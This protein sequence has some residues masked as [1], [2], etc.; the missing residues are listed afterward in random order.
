MAFG[1]DG[2]GNWESEL[3][4]IQDRD[5]SIPISASKFN[6]LIQLNLKQSLPTCMTIDSQTK[7]IANVDISNFKV[8]N[9]ANPTLPKDAVNK[10][11]LDLVETKVDTNTTNIG[12]NTTNIGTNTSAIALNTAKGEETVLWTGSAA[13]GT[14]T[15]SDDINNYK[16][17]QLQAGLSVLTS[18]KFST[19]EYFKTVG[20]AKPIRFS[21][22]SAST[23]IIVEVYY[24]DDFTIG[25]INSA[26]G[27]VFES[28]RGIK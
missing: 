5:D 18:T 9:V 15:L 4:P 10:Q 7:P 8:I 11:T 27:L 21:E 3:F 23:T 1:W 20:A 19:V 22:S 13:S 17:L 2:N 14:V 16:F 25:V 28:I 6:Q 24:I 26:G 12:T